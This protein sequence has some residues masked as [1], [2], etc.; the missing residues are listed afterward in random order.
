MTAEEEA[1]AKATPTDNRRV[2]SPT[3]GSRICLILGAL[4]LLFAA[5]LFWGPLGRGVA[6]GFPADCGSAAKPPGDTLGKAVCGSLNDERRTQALT[7]LV[8]AVIVAAG[9]VIAF[10]V[11]RV[12]SRDRASE[13]VQPSDE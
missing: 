7:A 8:A 2:W 6:G 5:Y 12:P 11:D 3:V 4:L 13:H 9:G 10:G 1:A